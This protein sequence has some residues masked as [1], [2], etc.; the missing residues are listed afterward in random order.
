MSEC[1]H[2]GQVCG[3]YA[4]GWSS[5]TRPDGSMAP[6][7]H[8]NDPERPDCYRRVTVYHEPLGTLLGVRPLPAGV[9]GCKADLSALVKDLIAELGEPSDEDNEW[10]DRVL[11]GTEPHVLQA[12][13]DAFTSALPNLLILAEGKWVLMKG[14][15]LINVFDGEMEAI[16][17]GYKVFGNVPFLVKKIEAK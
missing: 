9:T 8:P 6:L 1:A 3:D 13:L 7:C 17:E 14:D 4:G 12:E 15:R 5:V 11:D 16:A 10:A 2:C